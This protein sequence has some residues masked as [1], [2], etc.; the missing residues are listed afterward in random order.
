MNIPVV[1]AQVA[2]ACS[3]EGRD[4]YLGASWVHSNRPERGGV[5]A[6]M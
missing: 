6:A 3:Q 1:E 2:G 5:T 4:P